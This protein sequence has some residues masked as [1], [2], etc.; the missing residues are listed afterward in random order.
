LPE[1]GVGIR[2]D[3]DALQIFVSVIAKTG[4]DPDHRAVWGDHANPRHT[5]CTH[6]DRDPAR[7]PEQLVAV[8]HAHDERTDA[9]LHG[10]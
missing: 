9:A 1:Q 6:L 2:R 5:E 3:F 10:E 4:G 8:A 7:L